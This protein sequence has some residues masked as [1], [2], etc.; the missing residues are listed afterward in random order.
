M[1]RVCVYCGSSPGA[2]PD[3]ARAARDL[4]RTLASEGLGVVYGGS[5]VGLMGQLADGVLEGGGEV[6]GVIPRMFVNKGIDHWGLTEVRIV[7]SMHERKALMADLSDAF[8]ALPGGIG[9]IEEFFE[10]LTWAQLGIHGKPCGLLNVCGYYDK[11]LDFLDHVVA[12]RFLREQHRAM[13]LVA[14]VILRPRRKNSLGGSGSMNFTLPAAWAT[15]FRSLA[16]SSTSAVNLG[17]P[18]PVINASNPGS[19]AASSSEVISP[20]PSR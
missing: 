11:L 14:Q 1:K 15:I 6:I 13:V 16:A 3:Y 19:S 10:A 4:G 5:N 17:A 7:D 9:T 8:I 18:H 20:S 12:Q 2:R